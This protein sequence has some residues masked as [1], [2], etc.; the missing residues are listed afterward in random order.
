MK[1]KIGLMRMIRIELYI[2]LFCSL[3]VFLSSGSG[4]ESRASKAQSS[5]VLLRSQVQKTEKDQ[6]QK[7]SHYTLLSKILKILFFFFL[8]S[9]FFFFFFSFFSLF[10]IL[11]FHKMCVYNDTVDEMEVES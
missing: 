5:H 9:F 2:I 8:F 3:F 4:Q 6:E 7:V 1:A 10:N 11:L